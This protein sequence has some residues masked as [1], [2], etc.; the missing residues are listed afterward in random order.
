[1][2]KNTI[3]EKL[4]PIILK[5]NNIN[6]KRSLIDELLLNENK[7]LVEFLFHNKLNSNH[8]YSLCEILN[9]TLSSNDIWNLN[10]LTRNNLNESV[11]RL[12]ISHH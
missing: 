5:K 11:N 7:N 3:N 9:N 8:Y 1:M 12:K 2:L 6:K 4:T 10:R